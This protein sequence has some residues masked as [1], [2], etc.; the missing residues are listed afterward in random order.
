MLTVDL[1]LPLASPF[2]NPFG[3]IRA[4]VVGK[5]ATFCRGDIATRVLTPSALRA[6]SS[7]PL[8]TP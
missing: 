4:K 1:R 2:F 5:S 8:A 3:W 7:K 6:T